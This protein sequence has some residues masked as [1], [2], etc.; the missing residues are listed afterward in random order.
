ML[1]QSQGRRKHL[2]FN[3]FDL[4][5]FTFI[6]RESDKA[7]KGVLGETHSKVS[8]SVCTSF[9]PVFP[10]PSQ[11]ALQREGDWCTR[12]AGVNETIKRRTRDSLPPAAFHPPLF[13]AGPIYTR[14]PRRP[15]H[16]Q[17]RHSSQVT[18]SGSTLS[19]ER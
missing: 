15:R 16:P 14:Y 6:Y 12:A 3:I 8:K 2:L 17:G 18:Q 11:P 10:L 9:N 7:Y 19:N 1:L 5:Y 4:F 13:L